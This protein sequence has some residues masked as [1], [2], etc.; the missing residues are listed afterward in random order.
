MGA[1]E[2]F[3]DNSAVSLVWTYSSPW[4]MSNAMAALCLWCHLLASLM[5]VVGFFLFVCLLCF[6]FFFLIS[7]YSVFR[8]PHAPDMLGKYHSLDMFRTTPLGRSCITVTV[9]SGDSMETRHCCDSGLK[10][11][12]NTLLSK[13]RL[14]LLMD[15][16]GKSLKLEIT[17]EPPN[18][19]K[20]SIPLFILS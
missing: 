15:F 10:S 2:Y 17:N 14:F 5:Q 4:R 7:Y 6:V 19:F 8:L 1:S 20:L 12:S 18:P 11:L 9:S 13:I 16:N 3:C